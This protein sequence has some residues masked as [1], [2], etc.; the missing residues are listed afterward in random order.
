MLC[1]LCL[2]SIDEYR[3]GTSSLCYVVYVCH[4]L[5]SIGVERQAYVMLVYVCHQLMSIGVERQAY[6]MS[7]MFVIN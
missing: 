6:V 4:Q 1:R 5:M 2:S 3:C 7:S